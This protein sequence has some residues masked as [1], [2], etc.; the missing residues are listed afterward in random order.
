MKPGDRV[1]I[2]NGAYKGLLGTLHYHS[3]QVMVLVIL[4]TKPELGPTH[5]HAVDIEPG[6]LDTLGSL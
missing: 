5:F 1:R 2:K 6:L 3:G 4:D